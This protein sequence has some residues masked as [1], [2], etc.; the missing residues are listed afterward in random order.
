MNKSKWLLSRFHRY[1]LDGDQKKQQKGAN[2]STKSAHCGSLS[3]LGASELSVRVL[4]HLF[5][6]F[7]YGYFDFL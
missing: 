2:A 4:I 7:S 5:L 1:M 3:W 6:F